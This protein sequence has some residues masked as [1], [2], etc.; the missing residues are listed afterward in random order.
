M[1][2][3]SKYTRVTQGCELNFSFIDIGQ[4]SKYAS[5]SQYTSVTQGCVENS[6]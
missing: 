2:H 3:G 1:S 4:N 6:P 5:S